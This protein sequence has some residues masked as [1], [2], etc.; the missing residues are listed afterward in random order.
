MAILLTCAMP[1]HLTSFYSMK[2]P[3]V[4]YSFWDIVRY[5]VTFEHKSVNPNQGG[6]FGQSIVWGGTKVAHRTT[7]ESMSLN[8]IKI[9][10]T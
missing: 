8:L 6:L 4:P 9:Y 7:L 2:W 10:Q 5:V 1:L 3:R